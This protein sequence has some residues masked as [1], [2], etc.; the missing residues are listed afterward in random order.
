MIIENP[1]SCQNHCI[2]WTAVIWGQ[3][4]SKILNQLRKHDNLM[5]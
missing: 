3:F 4:I 1:S 5:E 2:T